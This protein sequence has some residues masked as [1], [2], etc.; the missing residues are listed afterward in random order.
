MERCLR[1]K[2][3]AAI[4]S[5]EYRYDSTMIRMAVWLELFLCRRDR[6]YCFDYNLSKL[7][8]AGVVSR[9]PVACP[10]QLN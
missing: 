6:Q 1:A 2:N 5:W 8:P 4:L 3:F 10:P 7:K 9:E